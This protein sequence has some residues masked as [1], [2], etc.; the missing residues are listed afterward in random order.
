MQL[1][2]RGDRGAHF[3]TNELTGFV[4]LRAAVDAAS[5][6]ALDPSARTSGSNLGSFP[7]PAQRFVDQDHR[8]IEVDLDARERILGL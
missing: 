4:I 6:R 1:S 8:G 5:P 7:S 2:R 3:V